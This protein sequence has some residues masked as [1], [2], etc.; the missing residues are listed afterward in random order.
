MTEKSSTEDLVKE[1]DF[2][3][4][5]EIAEEA[6]EFPEYDTSRAGDKEWGE[7]A[8]PCGG[9]TLVVYHQEYGT[10]WSVKWREGGELPK[11]LQGSY[12]TKEH[13]VMAINLHIASKD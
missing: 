12:T 5:S 4:F 2:L 11:N 1:D 3:S 6:E 7:V 10:F 8:F 9:K 13:A